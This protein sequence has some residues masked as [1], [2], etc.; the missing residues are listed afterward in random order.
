MQF[1]IVLHATDKS[2][3]FVLPPET[4][5]EYTFMPSIRIICPV[6]SYEPLPKRFWHDTIARYQVLFIGVQFPDLNRIMAVYTLY[7]LA[8]LLMAVQL[9]PSVLY[10]GDEFKVGN[11]SVIIAVLTLPL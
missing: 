7:I 11:V 3:V 10:V 5:P 8:K 6:T 1:V 2:D 4:L 9:S